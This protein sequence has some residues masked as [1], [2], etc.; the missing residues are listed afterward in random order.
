MTSEEVP[1]CPPNRADGLPDPQSHQKR[2]QLFI[3]KRSCKPCAIV[4]DFVDDEFF[5]YNFYIVGLLELRPLCMQ[6]A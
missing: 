1:P 2:D 5:L 4:Y 3:V 6:A